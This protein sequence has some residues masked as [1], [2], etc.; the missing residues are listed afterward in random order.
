MESR[1][2][3]K[4]G[5]LNL[6]KEVREG[7]LKHNGD[8]TGAYPELC[9]FIPCRSIEGQ[10]VRLMDTVAYTFHDFDDGIKS[11]ILEKN[12]LLNEDI[13]EAF[14]NI[15]REIKEIC[16]IEISCE[17]FGG[18][19]FISELINYFVENVTKK[20]YENL[21]EYSVSD[22]E[23]VKLLAKKGVLIAAL[24]KDAERLFSD[25]KAFV[26]KALYSTSTVQMMDVKAEGVVSKLYDAFTENS[27]LL[28]PEWKFRA[29][30]FEN[31]PEY[32]FGDEKK[33]MARLVCDYI[34]CMTDRYALEEYDRVFN[35]KVKI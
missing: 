28:P 27:F 1:V 30:N 24:E 11:G 17:K 35:P 32:N 13:R 7:I 9:P 5:G 14:L 26:D 33:S 25:F 16:G 12:C 29:D 15:K 19:S 21:K 18:L 22:Y 31:F 34:S 3:K 4:L 6:T 10:L 23:Y 8:R 2:N 20:T